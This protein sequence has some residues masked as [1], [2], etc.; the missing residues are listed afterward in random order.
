MESANRSQTARRSCR[1]TSREFRRSSLPEP[2]LSLYRPSRVMSARSPRGRKQVE[3]RKKTAVTHSADALRAAHITVHAMGEQF[4][5]LQAGQA[6][7]VF[8]LQTGDRLAPTARADEKLFSRK[9]RPVPYTFIYFLSDSRLPT[10]PARMPTPMKP[11]R[12]R[13]H[14]SPKP[15]KL[16]ICRCVAT[17]FSIYLY[18]HHSTK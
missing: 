17:S 12:T 3:I 2:H 7:K 11:S 13:C 4:F 10:M 16:I 6:K 15:T 8:C 18:A 9:K 1:F 14:T 5:C